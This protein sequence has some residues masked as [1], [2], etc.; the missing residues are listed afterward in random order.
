[1]NYLVIPEGL[2]LDTRN[3]TTLPS[4][5]FKEVLNKANEMAKAGDIIYI[6]PANF[7][8]GNFSEQYIGAK[9]LK[10]KNCKAE[11]IFFELNKKNYIDTFGNAHYLKLYLI[12]KD[13]WPLQSCNLIV[14]KI[15]SRRSKIIFH[16]LNYLF[17][18]IHEVDMKGKKGKIVKRLFYYNFPKIH[19]IY[20]FLS[21]VKFFIDF[22]LLKKLR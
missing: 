7:F 18:E 2:F 11:I 14:N 17:T 9:Y 8:G 4:F 10:N 19:A 1:M 20:E 12:D 15:H 5:V 3:N 22:Y 6:C 21:I 16:R 13:L